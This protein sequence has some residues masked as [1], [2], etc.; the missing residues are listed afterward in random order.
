MFKGQINEKKAVVLLSGGLDSVTVLFR[1]VKQYGAEHTKALCI[2]YGQA[3][4]DA[5][6]ASAALAAKAAGVS[7]DV[8]WVPEAIARGGITKKIEGAEADPHGKLAV[9]PNRNAVMISIAVSYGMAWWPNVGSIYVAVGC[10]LADA[11]AFPDCRGLFLDTLAH[12]LG[13]GNGLFVGIDAP[14]LQKRKADILE[15]AR[16]MGCLDQALE[17]WSCY[18]QTKGSPCGDCHACDARNKAVAEV[19]LTDR[20]KWPVACGGDPSRERA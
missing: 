20:A 6:R 19:K 7:L 5:E 15:D 10:N 8:A 2:H 11:I 13:A 3:N 1:T 17:S 16:V 18:R 14:Y 9:V 4:S 12:A